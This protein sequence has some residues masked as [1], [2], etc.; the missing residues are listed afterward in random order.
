MTTVASPE[1]TPAFST[2]SV[3]AWKRISPRWATASISTS[4]ASSMNLVMTTGCSP[5]IEAASPRAVAR[6]S[7]SQATRI[8]APEST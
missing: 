5:Q 3:I 1:W 6:L 4:F 7:R 2:C 8:A